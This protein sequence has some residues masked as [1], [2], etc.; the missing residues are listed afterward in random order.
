MHLLEGELIE[1]IEKLDEGW[2]T[3]V[4]DNGTKQGLFPGEP[5]KWHFDAGFNILPTSQLCGRNSTSG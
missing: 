2:W 5:G 4:G 1:E 3:G